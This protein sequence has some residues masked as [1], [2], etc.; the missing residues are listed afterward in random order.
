MVVRNN[1]AP[2]PDLIVPTN[3]PELA[4]EMGEAAGGEGRVV[5][6]V[7]KNDDML[8][9][10][11]VA[12]GDG[13]RVDTLAAA[14]RMNFKVAKKKRKDKLREKIDDEAISNGDLE[15]LIFLLAL[16]DNKSVGGPCLTVLLVKRQ[17][18][19]GFT[20]LLLQLL[21]FIR[22]ALKCA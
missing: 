17:C 11:K 18:V 15:I 9:D 21:L 6:G 8:G 7:G 16:R 1:C 22:V 20:I 5:V 12:A 14:A 3:S 13:E 2:L 19:T 10:V 4:T